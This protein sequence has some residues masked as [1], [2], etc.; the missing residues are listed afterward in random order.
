MLAIFQS[1]GKVPWF[2]VPQYIEIGDMSG[3]GM[4]M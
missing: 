2:R 1:D 3:K 4:E